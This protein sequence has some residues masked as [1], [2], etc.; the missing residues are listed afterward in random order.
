ML[1]L[2]LTSRQITTLQ[3][4]EQELLDWNVRFNLT[5]IRDKEGIQVKHFLDSMTCLLAMRESSPNRLIDIGTGAGFPGIPLKI[6]YPNLRLTLVEL[7]SK[8]ADFC[9]HVVNLLCL[10]GVEVLTAHAEE[11]GQSAAH[12]QQ[13][14]LGSRAG[15]RHPAGAGRI[16]AAAGQGRRACPGSKRGKRTRRGPGRGACHAAPGGT[17]APD[18]NGDAA[19][20]GR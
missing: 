15:S 10:E 5:A 16:S 19:R 14:R 3:K 4:Y 12:R 7:V 17:P 6:I 13:D 8:K 1:G 20:G 11:V 2:H 9:Q 18:S